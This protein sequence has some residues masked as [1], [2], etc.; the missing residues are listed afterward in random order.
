MA[1]NVGF[2]DV[3]LL[4]F[5]AERYRIFTELGFTNDYLWPQ[6]LFGKAKKM[7]L[8]KWLAAA[9]IGIFLVAA[10]VR[11]RNPTRLTPLHDF[12]EA[13]R[14]EGAR[15]MKL[16]HFAWAPIT[17]SPYLRENSLALPYL[18]SRVNHVNYHLER[19]PLVFNLMNLATVIV[20][21]TEL[22]Y[23]LPSFV[24]GI[25][26]VL[27][28]IIFSLRKDWRIAILESFLVL[29]AYDWWMSLQM[30][31]LD[32][33]VC[34]FIF[35]S[36][37]FM[38]LSLRDKRSRWLSALTAGLAVLSKGQMAVIL[39]PPV[40]FLWWQKKW[41]LKE[42][43]GWF[44]VSGLVLLPWILA[45]W[46]QFGMG[47]F[48]TIFTEKLFIQRAVVVD[49]SQKAPIYWYIRWWIDSF[50]PGTILFL[51]LLVADIREKKLSLSKR[52][53]LVFIVTTFGIFS[54]A[55]NKVWWYVMPAIP[56]VIA[57]IY[58]SVRERKERIG[59]FMLIALLSSLPL[60]RFG[61][62][63]EALLIGV[64]LFCSGAWLFYKKISPLN[65]TLPL[66][67]LFIIGICCFNQRFPVVVPSHSEIKEVAGRVATIK[68]EKCLF[69]D[70]VPY[71]GALFYS[72]S[73]QID[74]W[75]GKTRAGCQ[76]MV[77]S[78]TDREI[79]GATVIYQK[80]VLRLSVLDY[81]Q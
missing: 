68:G 71:E 69:V 67:V 47:T 17:G 66:L 49:I 64:V 54:V 23:R 25:L 31:Q 48:I 10:V 42:A 39:L 43:T 62:N 12:D 60:L 53:I 30:A 2:G 13:N 22:A 56:A 81:K 7:K 46:W 79:S 61:S 57:Y 77:I 5:C 37:F 27:G 1:E 32:T 21:E 72:K 36:L 28:I 35:L 65:A 78:T 40:L 34:L 19:P 52:L 73:G 50:R 74:L 8:G 4:C 51:L 38:V 24:M 75:Q 20:G 76:N 33:A 9:V 3:A 18:G 26:L 80:G 55:S 11:V 6:H 29:T 14:A 63:K 44:A 70:N 15:N 45:L 59:I 16:F 41:N 58:L